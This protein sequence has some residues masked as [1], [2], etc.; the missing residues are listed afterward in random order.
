MNENKR[1]LRNTDPQ[2]L[3]T[4]LCGLFGEQAGSPALNAVFRSVPSKPVSTILVVI[5]V[6]RC[7]INSEA[8]CETRW[9]V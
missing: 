6:T 2:R 5:L 4:S 3:I 9:A 7:K 8:V 1:K